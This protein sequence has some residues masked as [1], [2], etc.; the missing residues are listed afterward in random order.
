MKYNQKDFYYNKAKKEGFKARAAYKLMQIQ[1]RFKIIKQGDSVLDI[2]CAPGSW[3]QV[4][5]K[6]TN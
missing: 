2:A 4:I 6:L 3:L 1:Q 5:K